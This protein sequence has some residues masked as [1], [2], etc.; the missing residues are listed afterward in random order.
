MLS[1]Y[2]WPGN[3]REL[4]NLVER[5]T[6]LPESD[7]LLRKDFRDGLSHTVNSLNMIEYMNL[8]QYIWE[9]IILIIVYIM[10]WGGLFC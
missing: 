5:A 6:I 4:Q 2:H 3:V 1:E 7:T 10:G 9:G 8:Y